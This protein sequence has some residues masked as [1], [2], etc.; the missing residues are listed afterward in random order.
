M[1]MKIITDE[2][3]EMLAKLIYDGKMK[4]KDFADEFRGL[5]ENHIEM[6]KHK[7]I[8]DALNSKDLN[9]A[10]NKLTQLIK[11]GLNEQLNTVYGINNGDIW[12]SDMGITI[13]IKIEIF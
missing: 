1:R 9:A 13:N 6:Q 10:K 11:T 2:D 3:L 7:K 5:I 12:L 8:M 4:L